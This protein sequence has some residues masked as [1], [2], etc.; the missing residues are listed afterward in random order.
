MDHNDMT[1]DQL[2]ELFGYEPKRRP[3]DAR[4]AAALLGVHPSTLEGYRLRGGGP[5][6]FNPPRTRVVRYAERDLLVWLVASA[7]TSTSQ[8]LSA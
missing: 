4:E 7:R 5:R 2:C 8:A 6:F 1:F 3:L